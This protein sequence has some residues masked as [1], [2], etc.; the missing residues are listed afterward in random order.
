MESAWIGKRVVLFF[1]D[2]DKVL[3]KTGKITAMDEM[4]VSMEINGEI[5]AIPQNRIIRMEV[6]K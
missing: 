3:R 1:Q 5:Q 6:L 4:F 2:T